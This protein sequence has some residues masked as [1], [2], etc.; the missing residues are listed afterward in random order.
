MNFYTDRLLRGIS[1]SARI[2]LIMKLTFFLLL[3]G[4]LQVSAVSRAQ[5]VNLDVNNTSLEKVLN[6]LKNQAGYKLFYNSDML[7]GSKPVSVKLKN[8]E[9]QDALSIVLK[10]QNLSYSLV[11]NTIV[12]KKEAPGIAQRLLGMLQTKTI[13]GKIMDAE[14]KDGIP[15]ASISIKSSGRRIV[16]DEHGVFSFSGVPADAQLVFSAIG[17]E[18][19]T[20][21]V[22]DNMVVLLKL[23]MTMLN[24]TKIV[25]NGYEARERGKQTGSA[26]VITDKDMA[27]TPQLNLLEKLQGLVPGLYVDTRN[28]QIRIRGANAPS[29]VGTNA[30]NAAPLIVIDGFPTDDRLVSLNSTT[31]NPNPNIV[32]EPTTSGAA[33]LNTYN[34]E[35]IESITVLKDAVA[36]SIWGARA[37]NGVIVV[38]TKKGKKFQQPSIQFKTVVSTSAPA[39]LSSVDRMSTRDYIEFERERFNKGF[40]AD[41]ASAWRYA[42]VSEASEI[43]FKAKRGQIT[44]AERDAALDQLA[45]RS[46]LGQLR[47]Y[48]LQRS[49]SQ[50]YNL[51]F[52]GGSSNTTYYVSG[53]YQKDRPVF[54][55]NTTEAYSMIANTSTDIMKNKITLKTGIAY[56]LRKSKSNDAAVLALGTGRLG[57]S[58]Y[59]MLADENGN[60]IRRTISFT[61]RVADSLQNLGYKS[62]YYNP[63]EELAYNNMLR[64]QHAIRINAAVKG[65]FTDWLDLEVS[66]QV[67]KNLND[68][69]FLENANGYNMRELLNTSTRVTGANR[70]I[71]IP[72]GGIYRTA[73]TSSN[74]YTLR[75]QFNFNKTFA[76]VHSLSMIAGSEIRET[77]SRGYQQT[78][79]GY[80]EESASSLT[81]NPINYTDMFGAARSLTDNSG[82]IQ[83]SKLRYLSYYANANY[84]Y[85]S[86]YYLSGSI[87]F[88]DM[89]MV[90]VER[91]DRAIPLWSA[92][93]KWNIQDEEFMK[94]AY[95]INGLAMRLT[96]G[97]GGR[98]PR[99]GTTFTSVNVGSRDYYTTLPYASI[100]V[101]ANANLGWETTR[102]LNAGLDFAI[103]NKRLQVNFDHYWKKSY[104]I[105]TTFP[106][107]STYGWNSIEYNTADM[108]GRGFEL[109]LSGQIIKSREWSWVT[110]FNIAYATTRVTDSRYGS[111]VSGVGSPTPLTDQPVGTFMVYRWAGLNDKGQS[112]I[113]NADGDKISPTQNYV[114]QQKDLTV[115]GVVDPK[116]FG[117]LSSNVSFK[118]F[119]LYARLSYGFGHKFL[120]RDITSNSY[121]PSSTAILSTSKSLVNR[122]RQPG[123]ELNTDV[124]GIQNYNFNSV[125]WYNLSDRG[126]RDAGY[127]RLN[128]VGV[129]YQ[130]PED[131]VKKI[132]AVRSARL[133]FNVNN[134]GLIWRA[135]KDGLDPEYYQIDNFNNLPPTK[136]YSVDLTISF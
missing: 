122:W 112:Q 98:V 13:L 59:D 51:S 78:R 131:L 39:N 67:Q 116:Y 118:G 27:V 106:I 93:F 99:G 38:N 128:Q 15:K 102:T 55:S 48:M 76:G 68:Q 14:T 90:G 64:N 83:L 53:G 136:N 115:G 84:G 65:R 21:N 26:V 23:S 50:Q 5:K 86:K 108:T 47:D 96:I 17:Y 43:M 20:L 6:N 123:D 101:P 79:Y 105:L 57:L 120:K 111:M 73:N 25:Y 74:D 3:A 119:G 127:V 75:A 70:V 30:L 107:N 113:Y 109:A 45:Q 60:L 44:A 110:D 9:L 92:G 63:V 36:T 81:L 8:V 117:G 82:Q 37:A 34:P 29:A 58:P 11:N 121:D 129:S 130:L 19:Q 24:D 42:N 7:S 125:N 16:S 126:V 22:S 114:V 77:S 88:D 135:N 18:T 85:Q 32:Q 66:G 62:W 54:K 94:D 49:M 1:C 69:T 61:P 35:D 95:W 103:L 72:D 124:P 97:T 89:S 12:L 91:R 133:G 40:I 52:S 46:N 2:L 134:L 100:Y 80:D 28:N 56:T 71:G 104:D 4:F 132:G 10:G 33:I 31:L 87:R 41:P